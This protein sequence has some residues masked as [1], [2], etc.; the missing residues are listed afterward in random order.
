MQKSEE[1]LFVYWSVNQRLTHIVLFS[2]VIISVITGIPMKYYRLD[3][4]MRFFQ[5][6]DSYI[7]VRMIH[8]AAGFLILTALLYHI[9]SIIY[10][11][12]RTEQFRKVIYMKFTKN[13]IKDFANYILFLFFL[14]KKPKFGKYSFFE[15]LDYYISFILLAL[16]AI[17]GLIQAFPIIATALISISWLLISVKLHSSLSVLFIVYVLFSH[18]FNTHYH[19]GRLYLNTVWLFGTLSEDEMKKMHYL[20]YMRVLKR[21]VDLREEYKKKA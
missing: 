20:E 21:D 11:W 7:A 15:K 14:K 1:G 5:L 6:F 10:V 17:T 19:P 18:M 2:A 13:D 16:L 9:G 3:F 4:G 8:N 12:M